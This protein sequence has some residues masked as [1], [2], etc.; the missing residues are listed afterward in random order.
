MSACAAHCPPT[1]GFPGA[2]ICLVVTGIGSLPVQVASGKMVVTHQALLVPSI[3]ARL[4]LLSQLDNNHSFATI[5]EMDT[6]LSRD[7]VL[8]AA[9][10]SLRGHLISATASARSKRR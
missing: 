3:A 8:S 9:R 7:G 1:R 6:T 2:K 10:T 5:F 4:L